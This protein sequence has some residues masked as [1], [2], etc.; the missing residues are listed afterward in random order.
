[1][2]DPHP[3]SGTPGWVK[4]A[5]IITLVLAVLLVVAILAGGDHGPGRHTAAGSQWL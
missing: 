2:A 4:V 3:E 5:A 1:V